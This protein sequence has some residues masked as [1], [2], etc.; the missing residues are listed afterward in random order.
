MGPEGRYFT[1]SRVICTTNPA[2]LESSALRP[3][4]EQKRD[5]TTTKHIKRCLQK[6]NQ[7]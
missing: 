7:W 2:K 3:A 5:K 6:E 1:V 4:N